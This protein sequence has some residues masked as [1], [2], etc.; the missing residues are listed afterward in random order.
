MGWHTLFMSVQLGELVTCQ[1]HRES[2]QPSLFLSCQPITGICGDRG[3]FPDRTVQIWGLPGQG[4][5]GKGEQ[6]THLE[7]ANGHEAE[8]AALASI[9]VIVR[10]GNTWEERTKN[11]SKVSTEKTAVFRGMHF[12]TSL[13]PG[14]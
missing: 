7:P 10:Q 3:M 11:S 6:G 2:H 12:K 5:V 14:L 9:G 13:C 4:S 8:L 1:E